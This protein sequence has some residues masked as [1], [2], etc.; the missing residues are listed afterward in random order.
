MLPQ[1]AGL[2]KWPAEAPSRKMRDCELR[3]AVLR[4]VETVG[5]DQGD[6][7][8]DDGDG[9]RSAASECQTQTRMGGGT[10]DW[11]RPTTT[12]VGERAARFVVVM[13]RSFP[14]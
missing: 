9:H 6:D 1:H 8:E 2:L 13:V 11:G 12:P 7:Q 14:E 3:V 5:P 4:Y 10:R